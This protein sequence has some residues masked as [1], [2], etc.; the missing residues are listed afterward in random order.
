MSPYLLPLAF[1]AVVYFA[2]IYLNERY[3]LFADDHFPSTAAKVAAYLWLGVLLFFLTLEVTAS[4][5]HVTTKSELARMPF[6]QLFLLHAVLAVFLLGW[7]LLTKRPPIGKFLNLSGGNKGELVMI[8]FAVGVGGW[9]ITMV[10]ALLVAG[11]LMASGLLP[12]KPEISPMVAW[13]ATLPLWKKAM[14]VLSAMTRM[15]CRSSSEIRLHSRLAQ[16]VESSA[17]ASTSSPA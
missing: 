10:V 12:H 15:P 2:M 3:G 7:W 1:I 13:M 14:I 8:G 11:I 6:W 16:A 17:A 9:A 5:R 4:A